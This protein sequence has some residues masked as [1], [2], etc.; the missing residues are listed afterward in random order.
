[1]HRPAAFSEITGHV[2]K[3]ARFPASQGSTALNL[4]FDP[5]YKSEFF[6][7]ESID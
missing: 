6:R 4:D 7:E 1:M 5:E 3:R 2:N